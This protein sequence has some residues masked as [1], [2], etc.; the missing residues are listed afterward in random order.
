MHE[1]AK[2]FYEINPLLL[3]LSW[4]LLPHIVVVR[5]LVF[6]AMPFVH[7]GDGATAYLDTS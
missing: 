4:S 2:L 5:L 6:D 7:I 1:F 3:L